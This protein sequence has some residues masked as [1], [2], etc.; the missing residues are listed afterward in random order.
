LNGRP[1]A[2]EHGYPLR[3]IVPGWYGMTQIKWLNRIVVLDRRYEGRH[4]AR[5]YHSVRVTDDLVLETSISRNR[6]K[7]VVARVEANVRGGYEV[8]GAAWGGSKPI[9]KVEV[10]IDGSAVREA[11]FIRRS[12][13]E[14]W[15]LWKLDWPDA[16][17]GAHTLFS[18]AIDGAGR[19]Q[20]NRSE[21]VSAREDNTQWT[22]R[23][24]IPMK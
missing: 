1:L 16:A 13:P 20:P 15:S 14:A 2:P 6:L 3:L 17:P 8:Y 23:V 11:A 21:F 22:R 19:A 5:N 12:S 4:M 9:E 24:L 18:R 10:G 7:S